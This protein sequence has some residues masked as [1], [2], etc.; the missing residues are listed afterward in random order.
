MKL[1]A[2]VL[3]YCALAFIARFGDLFESISGTVRSADKAAALTSEKLETF[4]FNTDRED[5]ELAE[6]MLAADVLLIS[7]PPGVSVDPVLARFG[8][9]IANLRAP[10]IIVYLS[11]IGVYGDWQG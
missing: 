3:G 4:I 1:F 11:T 10:Q 7:I 8:H 2:F 6:K 5:P 9:R